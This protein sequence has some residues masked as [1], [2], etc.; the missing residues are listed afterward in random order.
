MKDILGK[1]SKAVDAFTDVLTEN[2]DST[3]MVEIY[4][5]ADFKHYFLKKQKENPEIKRVTISIDKVSEFG[6][7]VFSV[8]AKYS[9]GF[10]NSLDSSIIV[11]ER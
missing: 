3:N 4:R 1:I 7:V 9:C 11:N 2:V 10:S 6:N 8:S 5:Y